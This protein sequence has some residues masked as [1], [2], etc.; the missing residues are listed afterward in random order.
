MTAIYKCNCTTRVRKFDSQRGQVTSYL[1]FTLLDL[2]VNE[3]QRID[4]INEHFRILHV[5]LLKH[6]FLQQLSVS[7]ISLQTSSIVPHDHG[8]L[9][10]PRRLAIQQEDSSRKKRVYVR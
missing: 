7:Q 5:N 3:F 6:V 1:I 4:Y 10:I 9:K 2:W 8:G